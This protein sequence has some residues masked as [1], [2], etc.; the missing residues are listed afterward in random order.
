VRLTLRPLR[1][2]LAIALLLIAPSLRAQNPDMMDPDKSAAKAQELL[3]QLIDALGGQRYLQ[4]QSLQCE[5]RLA[6]FGH[7]GEMTGFVNFRDFRM[8]PDKKRTDIGKKGNI[9]DLFSGDEGWTL[10]RGG[11]SEEPAPAVA[12]FQEAAMLITCSAI[13][14]TKIASSSVTA[15]IRLWT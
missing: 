9:I 3:R 5:G 14:S 15:A 8:F 4:L 13:A 6:Q 11:V 2:C 10:D 1:L 7:N 12:D